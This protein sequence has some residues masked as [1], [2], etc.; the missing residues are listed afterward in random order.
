MAKIFYENRFLLTKKL[1]KQYCSETYRKMRKSTQLLA[2]LLA[3]AT[4]IIAALVFIF[5]HGRKSMI[6]FA[7]IFIY[8]VMMCFFGYSFS[9]WFNYRS[10][11]R[12]YGEK[13]GGEIVYQIKFEP[14]EIRV[15]V[16]ETGFTF[17]YTTIE[18]VYETADLYIFI[19][20]KKGMIEHGQPVYKNG[21]TD[22]SPETIESFK[23]FINE[24]VG[25][26]IF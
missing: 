12:D 7:V 16:G 3:L 20:S 23:N 8:F 14:K 6:I 18:K 25:K 17:K 2:M 4:V 15:K 1:H 24:K 13:K 21:F 9:E 11:K 10:L 5:L 26:D 22:K 19:L